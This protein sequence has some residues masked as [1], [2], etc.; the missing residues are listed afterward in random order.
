MDKLVTQEQLKE[1]VLVTAETLRIK[2]PSIIEKDYYVTHAIHSLSGIENEYFRLVFA[3]GTCLAKAHRIVKRM[4]EDIDFKIQLK[5][6]S[7]TFSKSRLLN[8]LKKFRT[9]IME[10]LRLPNL[11]VSDSAVRNTGQYLR[12]ELAY[13]A[14]FTGDNILRPHLLLEFTFA[15]IR[16]ATERLTVNTIIEDVITIDKIFSPLPIDCISS[17]E[18]AIEKWVGLTRRI[19]AIER[20][21]QHDDETLVRHVYDLNAIRQA[22]KINDVFFNLVKT[23]I[24]YDAKQFKNQHPEYFNDPVAEIRQSLNLLKNK[25]IWKKRY[26]QFV[27]TMVYDNTSIHEYESAISILA[28]ISEQ[29]LQSLS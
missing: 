14:L 23:I 26:Q 6:T 22:N 15:D 10:S 29:A 19:A 12:A 3:G 5:I 21:Y 18:T 8:E 27:G 25:P 17:D 24:N 20:E 4:S 13:P 1:L 9:Q 11:T 28:N 2:Y 7:E 16:L